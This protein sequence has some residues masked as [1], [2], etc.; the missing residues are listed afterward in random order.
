MG[1]LHSLGS[2]LRS[3]IRTRRRASGSNP[4]EARL[5]DGRATFIS[6]RKRYNVRLDNL[7]DQRVV[8]KRIGPN[9]VI[10][11]LNREVLKEIKP[12]HFVKGK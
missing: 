8:M 10:F 7:R 9:F 5:K 4:Y 12:S 1:L 3:A 11:G 6:G 2:R